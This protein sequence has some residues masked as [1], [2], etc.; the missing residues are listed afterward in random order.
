MRHFLILFAFCCLT[1]LSA[2]DAAQKS[3]ASLAT[4]QAAGANL[5]AK[6]EEFATV[7]DTVKDKAT[8]ETAKPKLTKLNKE[9]EVL[10]KEAAALG[11]PP[12]SI[13]KIL[14]ND[15]KMQVRAQN[16]T[17][18]YI[19]ATQRVANNKEVLAVL[20]QTMKDFQRVSQPPRA[21]DKPQK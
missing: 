9:I 15:E 3:T 4:F 14:D 17:T 7:L 10:S 6:L 11:E 21:A 2:Q 12:A 1:P 5:L 13:A 8:A 19:T 18:K 16:F 20:I